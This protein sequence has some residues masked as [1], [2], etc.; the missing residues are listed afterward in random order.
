[1]PHTKVE[2]NNCSDII[3]NAAVQRFARQQGL[4]VWAP[5]AQDRNAEQWLLHQ[6]A[7]AAFVCGNLGCNF[8]GG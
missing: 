4:G 2:K 6:D 8:A 5:F 7:L 3:H 1:M